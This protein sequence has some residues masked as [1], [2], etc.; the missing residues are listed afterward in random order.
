[1][2]QID[3]YR[4]TMLKKRDELVK[5]NQDMAREQAKL[6]PLQKKIIA[7]KNMVSRTK[8][9]TTMK[10][11]LSEIDR[12]SKSIADIQAKCGS[13]QSKIAN[14]EKE[15]AAAEK[16]YRNEEVRQIKKEAENEKKRQQEVALRTE[17]MERTLRSQ[18]YIQTQMQLDI[19]RL[20][21]LPERI[22]ILFLASNPVIANTPPLRIDE[23]ARLI[24]E[25]IRLSEYRDSIDFQSRWA[26]RS[27]D[28]LQAI[29]ETN[30]TII[31]FSGHGNA[32]GELA[33]Q[34]PN[35]SIKSVSV[36]AISMAI[37]TAS[38][39]V[40][41]VVFNACFSELQAANVIKY[42]DV[43]IGM[44]DAIRDDTA[45][46]FAAQFY[47]SIGFGRSLKKSFS[48][49]IAALLLEGVPGEDIP[50]IH[51]KDDVDLDD[52]TLVRPDIK[53]KGFDI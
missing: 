16:N 37:S 6:A 50:K 38:D 17:S 27:S 2:S 23:E 46:I 4:S 32:K 45:R 22:T 11:K 43:A 36:E 40:R 49:A 21:A 10:S 25:K 44:S 51:F 12:H 48:Q 9:Q 13:I 52:V 5:L 34:N 7:A 31:H 20:K 15:L 3:T 33:L 1:M 39:T 14:K 29:N 53:H 30:P 42:I 47:A 41:L 8:T 24:Q 35:G 19:E 18:G 26:T 28:I